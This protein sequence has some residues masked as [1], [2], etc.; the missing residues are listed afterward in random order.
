M[1]FRIYWNSLSAQQAVSIAKAA[2]S[3]IDFWEFRKRFGFS[4]YIAINEE[5][6]RRV[7]LMMRIRNGDE[8][9]KSELL[10]LLQFPEGSKLLSL[11]SAGGIVRANYKCVDEA[12]AN[13][14]YEIEGCLSR[15]NG[16]KVALA[17]VFLFSDDEKYAAEAK[18]REQLLKR[19]PKC[20]RDE[21]N[22]RLRG[23]HYSIKDLYIERQG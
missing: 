20:E 2:D 5:N 17:S 10:R 8:K 15:N 1:S 22:N 6:V 13:N 7:E 11:S 12:V 19:L 21:C 9:A 18:T 23:L 14:C 4:K 16:H 3:Y